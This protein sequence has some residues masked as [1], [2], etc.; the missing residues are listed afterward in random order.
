MYKLNRYW[1][2][3]SY[4][5]HISAVTKTPFKNTVYKSP[6]VWPQFS[7]VDCTTHYSFI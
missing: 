7:A 6:L 3:L 2:R 1:K 5:H 4:S